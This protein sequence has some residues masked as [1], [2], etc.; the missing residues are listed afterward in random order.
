MYT[1]PSFGRRV[2]MDSW[3]NWN[4][5]TRKTDLKFA[6][7]K[8][9]QII[10]S[11][12]LKK[13]MNA[14]GYTTHPTSQQNSYVAIAKTEHLK[15]LSERSCCGRQGNEWWISC[16]VECSCFLHQDKYRGESFPALFWEQQLSA[17][18]KKNQLGG[19]LLSSNGVS[20]YT[21]NQVECTIRYEILE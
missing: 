6:I 5:L 21:I 19:T 3:S 4:E 20:T 8:V 7:L 15:E 2:G 12:H 13:R 14:W 11:L 17:A 16:H 18:L 1:P 10:G 9:V